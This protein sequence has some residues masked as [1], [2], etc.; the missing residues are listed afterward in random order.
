MPV[1]KD[2]IVARDGG[3][4]VGPPIGRRCG[5]AVLTLTA[6]ITLR[7]VVTSSVDQAKGTHELVGALASATNVSGASGIVGG[8]VHTF[9]LR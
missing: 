1:T 7:V 3:C 2:P 5:V 6:R 9:V 4:P 8:A